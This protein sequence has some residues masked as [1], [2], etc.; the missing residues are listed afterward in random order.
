MP[1][2]TVDLE[3]I[4]KGQVMRRVESSG[5]RSNVNWLSSVV[6]GKISALNGRK[7]FT[8]RKKVMRRKRKRE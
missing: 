3:Y 7:T 1:K 5:K 6:C 2:K 8:R 4:M